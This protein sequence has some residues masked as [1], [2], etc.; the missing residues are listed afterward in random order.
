MN[1]VLVAPVAVLGGQVVGDAV[2]VDE[3]RLGAGKEAGFHQEHGDEADVVPV[4]KE[5][6]KE[7]DEELFVD[8]QAVAAT[9]TALVRP[10]YAPESPFVE[11]GQLLLISFVGHCCGDG[12][13][14][15][16]KN[17]KVLIAGAQYW[18]SVAGDP[19][20][21]QATSRAR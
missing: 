5:C 18:G 16:P 8:A 4:D 12:W 7:G 15:E 13:L 17:S 20:Q 9:G 19:C 10:G 6:G 3:P 14:M 21:G 2:S 1:P 11:L